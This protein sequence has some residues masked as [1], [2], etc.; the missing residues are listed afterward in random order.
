MKACKHDVLRLFKSVGE[1]TEML[2]AIK[3]E[4]LRWHPD[5]FA[6]VPERSRAAV[7]A[8]ATELF[9]VLGELE[10][11]VKEMESL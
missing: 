8:K 6:G 4:K 10:V 3:K 2:K 1:P 5:R 9:Q 11:E 7:Q